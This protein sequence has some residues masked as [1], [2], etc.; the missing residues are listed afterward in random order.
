[1]LH[2]TARVSA[3][4]TVASMPLPGDAAP[5]A[6]LVARLGAPSAAAPPS[7]APSSTPAPPPAWLFAIA[8]F[9]LLTEWWSRRL[10]GER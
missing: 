6:D 8:A 3:A 1:L 5:Y 4:R 2:R 7:D 9:A 10:R